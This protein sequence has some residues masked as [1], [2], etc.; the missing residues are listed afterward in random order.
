MSEQPISSEELIRKVLLELQRRFRLAGRGTVGRVERQLKLGS[1][2]FKD[3]R[4]PGRQRFDL[5][6]L[7]KALD[8]LGVEPAEFFASVLGS[9]DPISSFKTEA[10][11]LRRVKSLPRI[12]EL[13]AERTRRGGPAR[14]PLDRE[15]TAQ[16]LGVLDG[17]RHENPGLVMRRTRALVEQVADSQVPQLLGVYASAARVAGHN[18]A[19]HMVLVRAL[20]LAEEGQ[21]YSTR[22][23][24]LLRAGDVLGARGEIETA[25]ALTERASLTFAKSGDLVGIGRSLVEQGVWLGSL[26][27]PK[28]AQRVLTSALDYFPAD[29][30]GADGEPD[31]LVQRSRFSCLMS[32]GLLHRRLGELE[33]ALGY[34]Q[35][36][37][38]DSRGVGDKLVGRLLVLQGSIARQA[39]RHPQAEDLFREAFE[40]FQPAAPLDTALCGVELA[41]VQLQQS[42]TTE[43]YNT[44]SAMLPLLDPLE[45][46]P[47]ASAALGELV[48]SAV[49][50][51]RRSGQGLSQDL[52]RRV[53]RG[54]EAGREG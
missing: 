7:F 35:Q 50:G 30:V 12:L 22:G 2:Y 39:G 9:T 52:L 51:R 13:E 20:D 16:D 37:R 41:R 42:K 25:L 33:T 3:Q 48:R 8:A 38:Q 34:L 27:R 53:A 19:A 24:L 6:I 29:A 44:V 23:D 46:N 18:E 43:A 17:L 1:G 36:A 10:A 4:R 21:D 5:K 47:A 49:A 32:L 28:K 45:K 14:R 11:V 54:L 31:L 40:I 15:E 26:D